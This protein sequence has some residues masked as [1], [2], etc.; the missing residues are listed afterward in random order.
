MKVFGIASQDSLSNLQGFVDQMG[1]TYPVYLGLGLRVRLGG[2]QTPAHEDRS[3]F[4]IRFPMGVAIIPE[5]FPLEVFF[6]VAPILL[7]SPS[8]RGGFDGGLGARV[9]L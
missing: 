7:V 1:L 9:Y 2:P 4:G 8:T 6:E 5:Q 3:S